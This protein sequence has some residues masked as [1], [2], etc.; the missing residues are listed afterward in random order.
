MMNRKSKA[1][2]PDEQLD[3]YAERI[4][5]AWQKTVE[6]IFETGRILTEVRDQLEHGRWQRLFDEGRVPLSWQTA[7]RFIRIWKA[8]D[9][10]IGPNRSH[11]NGLPASYST[12]DALAALPEDT[13]AWAQAEGRITPNME[14][15]SVAR[16]HTSFASAD[17]KPPVERSVVDWTDKR[18]RVQRV[19]QALA[20]ANTLAHEWPDEYSLDVFL[21]AVRQLL[22]RLERLEQT[23]H[24]QV[25]TEA[26]RN[27]TSNR[28]EANGLEA[29]VRRVD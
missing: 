2:A 15:A 24:G 7:N 13:L 23:N 14:R 6:S 5:A 22:K 1:L 21:F 17:E 29:S 18:G 9:R 4:T 28:G 25:S 10:L 26:T 16:L 27:A 3:G 19:S 8:R 11:V 20:P 12:L